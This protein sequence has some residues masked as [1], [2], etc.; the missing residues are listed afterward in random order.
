MSYVCLGCLRVGLCMVIVLM[1]IV[2]G[3]IVVI[4][5]VTSGLIWEFLRWL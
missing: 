4:R 5:F 1:S 3:W 2:I